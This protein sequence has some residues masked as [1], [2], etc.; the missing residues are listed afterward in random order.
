MIYTV[1]F[2]PAIDYVLHPTKWVPGEINRSAREEIYYGGK[3]INI[4]RVLK[5]L[6]FDSV[7]LGFAAGFTG[8]A[9]IEG[10]A[11]IGIHTDFIMLPGGMTR[12]NV[13]IRTESETDLNAAGPAIDRLSLEKLFEK[14][15]RLKGGDF[16]C[17]AGSVPPALPDSIYETI[18][19]GLSGKNIR[20]IVDTTG[21]F[22][23]RVLKY[24]PFLIKPNHMELGELFGTRIETAADAV[25]YAKR[26]Q[27]A[28][29]RNV[30]VSM[31]EKGAVLL[32]EQGRID[33]SDAPQ[34]V[35]KNSV[36]A[37]DSMT[38][39]FLA[40]FLQS[41][42]Y[43]YALRLGIAAGS[44]TAFADGLASRQEIDRI[45]RGL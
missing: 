4:S 12:I 40:G 37:G 39:G 27:D 36:G 11:T 35:L 38:A 13:K 26:L 10:L 24:R 34:G 7:A 33:Q 43:E 25:E 3:G 31:A 1:T 44:A 18:L 19:Q 42:D 21:A 41:G 5:A 45:L 2:N 6:G 22:L 15:S 8:Q 16:L 9:L 28:G 23:T 17:L 14:L 30:L 20:C 29:A 32:T